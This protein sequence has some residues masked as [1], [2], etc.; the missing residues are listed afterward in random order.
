MQI[1]RLKKNFQPKNLK[2]KFP[3]FQKFFFKHGS[4]YIKNDQ[5]QIKETF[6]KN[7]GLPDLSIKSYLGKKRKTRKKFF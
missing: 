3:G 1:D 6:R 7:V 2:K 4:I 5:N